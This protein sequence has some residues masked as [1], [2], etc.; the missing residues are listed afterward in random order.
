MRFPL[1]DTGNGDVIMVAISGKA[2][3]VTGGNRGIGR[4]LVQEALDRG[5]ERVYVGTRNAL[6]VSDSR[7]TPLVRTLPMVGRFET[8]STLSMLSTF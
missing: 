5:A 1:P 7:V 6:A 8:L 4:S 2:V 3:L